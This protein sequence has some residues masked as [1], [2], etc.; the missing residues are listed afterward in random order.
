MVTFESFQFV[1][2]AVALASLG[3][4]L[5]AALML[6][7]HPSVSVN[8][9]LAPPLVSGLPLLGCALAYR[10][11]PCGFLEAQKQRHGGVFTLNLAGCRIT[12]LSDPVAI[13]QYVREKES[14]V[15]DGGHVLSAVAAISEFGFLETLGEINTLSGAAVHRYMVFCSLPCVTVMRVIFVTHI[16]ATA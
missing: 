5:L 14:T 12:L 7:G 3:A 2:P 16:S 15:E 1:E 9:R 4:L 11:D 8:R 13:A 6:K 10:K